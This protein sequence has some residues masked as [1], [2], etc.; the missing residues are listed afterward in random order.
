[1]YWRSGLLFCLVIIIGGPTVLLS[2]PSHTLRLHIL[3]PVDVHYF[4][5]PLKPYILLRDTYSY[6]PQDGRHFKML[7]KYPSLLLHV[8][9]LPP[10]QVLPLT[11]FLTGRNFGGLKDCLWSKGLL[12]AKTKFS[13]FSASPTHTSSWLGV[14]ELLSTL[15]ILWV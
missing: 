13:N 14:Y 11:S 2:W 9:E 12:A 8:R 5:C 7:I 4:R 15:E 1:M 3:E 6:T 10:S